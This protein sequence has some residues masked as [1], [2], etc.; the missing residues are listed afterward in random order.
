MLK[1]CTAAA[2]LA[3]SF[4]SAQSEV[5]VEPGDFYMISREE[6]GKFLA[7]HKIFQ[8]E[9]DGLMEVSYC[10]RAFWV[11]PKTVAWT[12][13]ETDNLHHVRLEYNHGKGWVSVCEKPTDHVTLKLLGITMD[14]DQVI[15][16][17]GA[18]LRFM[19]RFS[20]ISK[21]FKKRDTTADEQSSAPVFP[22]RQRTE[23]SFVQDV[24]FD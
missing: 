17:D 16:S 4:S 21:S 11:R 6:D 1:L 8:R 12:E 2:L 7:S 15:R 10:G 22:A 24:R 20:A 3:M 9:S 5:T 13:L 19:T 18:A 23:K 14:A